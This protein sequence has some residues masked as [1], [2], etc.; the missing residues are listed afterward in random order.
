MFSKSLRCSQWVCLFLFVLMAAVAF[1]QQAPVDLPI[2]VQ[3]ME[4]AALNNRAHYHPYIL[5]RDYRLYGANTQERPKSE[6]KAEINFVPPNRQDYKILAT[7]GNSHGE[8]IVR[9]LLEDQSKAAANGHAPGAISRDNYD[10]RYLGEARLDGHDCYLLQL[11]PKREEKSLIAGRA[12]VDKSTYLVRR[13]DGEMS[14]MPSWW[15]KSVH[16]TLDFDELG[17]MWLQENTRAIADV[18]IVGVHTFTSKAVSIQSGTMD[19]QKLPPPRRRS[20]SDAVLGA[21]IL[22]H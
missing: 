7:A 19:A 22:Q 17:G 21:E 11:L 12:W 14:K 15:L 18:R 4:Q 2:I 8:S 9:H 1:G 5:T 6:V 3:R 13:I 10:F 20:R 16:V